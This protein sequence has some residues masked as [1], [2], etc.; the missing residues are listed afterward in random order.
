MS[1]KTDLV[2]SRELK[3]TLEQLAVLRSF[4]REPDNSLWNQALALI[5][6]GVSNE[7]RIRRAIQI[8]VQSNDL[9][10]LRILQGEDGGLQQIFTSDDFDDIE[11][12]DAR[13]IEDDELESEINW[14]ILDESE[15]GFDLSNDFPIRFRLLRIRDDQWVVLMLLHR[16]VYHRGVKSGYMQAFISALKSTGN[17]DVLAFPRPAHS[18]YEYIQRLHEKSDSSEYAWRSD[19]E[20]N[21]IVLNEAGRVDKDLSDFQHILLHLAKTH[22]V[23]VPDILLSAALLWNKMFSRLDS[24][25]VFVNL[26]ETFDPHGKFG[27]LGP[28]S[29]LTSISANIPVAWTFKDLALNVSSEV[30]KARS[31][32]AFTDKFL[33]DRQGLAGKILCSFHDLDS[34]NLPD[35]DLRIIWSDADIM[36]TEYDLE[37][38]FKTS[39]NSLSLVLAYNQAVIGFEEAGSWLQ[40]L[41]FVISGLVDQFDG[42]IEAFMQKLA[43]E[44]I[45]LLQRKSLEPWP[46]Q[47]LS[48][49]TDPG[50]LSGMFSKVAAKYPGNIAVR[51]PSETIS[52]DELNKLT[53]SIAIELSQ[54]VGAGKR[55]GI[56]LQQGLNAV[57]AILAVLKSGNAYVPLDVNMPLQRLRYIVDD[58]DL[59]AIITDKT[60]TSVWEELARYQLQVIRLEE[61]EMASEELV[62]DTVAGGNDAY[63]IYTSGST[64]TPKGVLQIHRNVMHYIKTYSRNLKISAADSLTLMSAYFFDA[65]VVDIFSALLNGATLVVFDLKKESFSAVSHRMQE[66]RVTIFHST[67]TV[68][69]YFTESLDRDAQF[70]IIRYVVLGGEQAR[71]GDLVQ[72]NEHF[73]ATASLVNLYGLSEVTIVTLGFFEH[74]SEVPSEIMPIGGPIDSISVAMLSDEGVLTPGMGQIVVSGPFLAKQYW[75]SQELTLQKFTDSHWLQESRDFLT[76]DIGEIKSDGTFLHLG[77]SDFQTKIRG[78]RVEPAEIESKI[79]QYSGVAKCVVHP[80]SQG[81]EL[82]LVAFIIPQSDANLAID[83]LEKFLKD[84]LPD[85]MIPQFFLPIKV[86]PQTH[87]GKVNR[88]KLEEIA[89][90]HF[91]SK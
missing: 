24:P 59:S 76:G 48:E 41:T 42:A 83:E 26:P 1:I 18:Y 44:R 65:A 4:H 22:E 13:D 52:Y 29:H 90:N 71:R 77:R 14:I 62:L 61:H 47:N 89:Q 31:D 9:F 55:I 38:I 85:Y 66:S 6:T 80:V 45:S 74:G 8:F 28:F 79:V 46:I 68:F 75:N 78:Y 25:D 37:F 11:S 15:A 20:V 82:S 39:S 10:N 51:T 84:L 12:E 60:S 19:A 50:S 16:L 58:A 7:A 33:G 5:V 23:T 70:Q 35:Q 91:L 86:F 21:G 43:L 36:S 34:F 63:I 2:T 27:P 49:K 40:E 53:D 88:R 72:F 67:P 3:I 17:S 57:T 56:L 30:H 87:T 69:R 73:A 81:G 32:T 64:G 54:R